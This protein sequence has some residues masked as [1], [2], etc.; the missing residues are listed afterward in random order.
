MSKWL[1]YCYSQIGAL[2]NLYL[3]KHRSHPSRTK[4]SADH[5]TK[6]LAED[7]R[8]RALLLFTLSLSYV[9]ATW[10]YLLPCFCLSEH[11]SLSVRVCA[12]ACVCGC[13]CQNQS[14][15]NSVYSRHTTSALRPNLQSVFSQCLVSV[16]LEALLQSVS[17]QCR[18]W[19]PPWVSGHRYL[20]ECICIGRH[21]MCHYFCVCVCVCV[22]KSQKPGQWQEMW[23]K[24]WV[25][26]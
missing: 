26:S 19:S 13:W 22:S 11:E 25:K 20:Y 24:M 4:R 15:D 10:V 5:I 1:T 18:A 2:E 9:C 12:C 7:D 16:E 6:R 23:V 14:K 21:I 17:S 8:V 3:F